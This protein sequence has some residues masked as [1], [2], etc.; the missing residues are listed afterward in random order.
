VGDAIRSYADRPADVVETL[1]HHYERA[2]R[3]R[4]AEV[5][6]VGSAEK[7]MAGSRSSRR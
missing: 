1:A 7:A 6:L 3:W 4:D 5:Y 2:E